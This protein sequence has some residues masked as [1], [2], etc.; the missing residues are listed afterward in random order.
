MRPLTWCFSSD[1]YHHLEQPEKT[2]ASLRQALKPDG[3]LV[4]VEFDRVEG[5]SSAFVSS[6]CGPAGCVSQGDRI[7]RLL[8]S[9]G[10]EDPPAFKENFFMRFEKVLPRSDHD[11]GDQQR[12]T[13]RGSDARG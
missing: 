13:M 4:V 6:T 11:R 3:K 1:V 8:V 7:G 10:G 9:N 5:R 2:L 12:L